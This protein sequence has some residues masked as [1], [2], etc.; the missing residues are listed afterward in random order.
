M[1]CSNSY[2]L[3]DLSVNASPATKDNLTINSGSFQE[4]ANFHK[5]CLNDR[6]TKDGA[7][8][9]EQVYT[10][11]RLVDILTKTLHRYEW[12]ESIKT[13]EQDSIGH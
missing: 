1:F 5:K 12:H 9:V 8:S 3:S 6:I 13:L 10:Y 11:H 4:H 2:F 7:I